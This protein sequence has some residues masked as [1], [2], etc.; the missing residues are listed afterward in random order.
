[1]TT[2][3]EWLS[4]L[5]HSNEA[6]QPGPPN[7]LQTN[8]SRFMDLLAN[9]LKLDPDHR[10]DLQSC[11]DFFHSLP[12]DQLLAHGYLQATLF[13]IVELLLE[14]KADYTAMKDTLK[15]VQKSITENLDLTT[16]QKAEVTAVTKLMVW[17]PTRTNFEND[18]IV[19]ASLEHLKKG[20]K[21]NGMKVIFDSSQS[22]TR[23]LTRALG[24]SASYAKS[25]FRNFLNDSL[26][27][28]AATC[29]TVTTTNGM[30]KFTGS[31]ENV[32]PKHAIQLVILRQV[33]R[34]NRELLRRKSNK[35]V[36]E[37]SPEAVN[38][39]RDSDDSESQ[40]WVVVTNFFE[41][42]AKL[43]G[44]DRK[45]SG[46]SGYLDT[47]VAQERKLFPNDTIPLIP[48]IEIP[49]QSIPSVR[50][51]GTTPG[52]DRPIAPL[53]QRGFSGPLQLSRREG[54]SPF[55]NSFESSMHSA[56]RMSTPSLFNM[57]PTPG[58]DHPIRLP[59]LQNSSNFNGHHA[60]YRGSSSHF[61]STSSDHRNTSP[62][63]SSQS[64]DSSRF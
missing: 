1:M 62:V 27:G 53:P 45:S 17:D 56:P 39:T 22:R 54:M 23:V 42:K 58:N 9:T 47:A 32:S 12:Q 48:H 18:D 4:S 44:T 60:D 43:W 55:S 13:Q 33:G 64:G 16:A 57:S 31:G 30:K 29:L 2:R 19:K 46:W 41:A 24:R 52:M 59:A 28:S 63:N 10:S 49:P 51:G 40:F 5:D 34:D 26:D 38:P 15:E 14:I 61:P 35:R 7:A 3:D 25:T 11:L 37:D 21:T 20:Q 8:P 50:A 6:R 36:H